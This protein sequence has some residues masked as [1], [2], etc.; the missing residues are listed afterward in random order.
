MINFFLLKKFFKAKWVY[1]K[2]KH[3]KFIIYDLTHSNYLFNYIKKEKY[4][5]N[6]EE[7]Q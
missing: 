2:P 1:K 4:E 5:K 6:N 3:K 7:N